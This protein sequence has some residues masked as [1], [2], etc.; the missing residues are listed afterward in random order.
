MYRECNTIANDFGAQESCLKHKKTY[1]WR[2]FSSYSDNN[3]LICKNEDCVVRYAPLIIHTF[4]FI[5]PRKLLEA[6]LFNMQYRKY[7]EI[8]NVHDRLRWCRHHMG[9][10]Q[11]DVAKILDISRKRY[12][13]LENGVIKHYEKEI[14]DKLSNLYQIPVKEL[15]DD[16]SY[17]LYRGQGKVLQE[18]RKKNHLER[19]E[20]AEMVGL[21]THDITMWENEEIEISKKVWERCF[22]KIL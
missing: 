22:K 18:Y 3:Y 10:L 17:F 16:Y 13:S 4:R 8:N 5:A 1:Q 19:S 14:V 12:T 11:K 2:I 9:L 21:R 20:L 7:E 6:Q 15:L